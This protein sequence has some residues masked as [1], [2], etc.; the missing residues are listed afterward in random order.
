MEKVIL[1][2]QKRAETGKKVKSLRNEGKLPAVIYGQELGSIPL[3]LDKKETVHTL[4]KGS[5]STLLTIKLE[6]Q[7]HA[8]LVRE[9][10]RDYLKNEVLHIDFLA[11]SLKE[12]LRTQVSITLVGDAPV[13]E[14]FEA[15]IV[16]GLTH[17]EVECLPQDL[18]ETIEVDLTGLT[19]IGSAIYVKDIAIPDK[20]E[21]VTSPEELIAVAS[22]VK[23][24]AVEEVEEELLAEVE[25]GAEPEV[26]EKGKT[27]EEGEAEE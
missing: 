24:E 14:E 11:V 21:I 6:G 7:E 27:E 23:E 9:I 17:I 1:E 15:L 20:V 8:A 2:A 16:A 22:A 13:L 18:P 26:I 4:S 5:G 3:T 19:E 25:E 10:Q 12:K